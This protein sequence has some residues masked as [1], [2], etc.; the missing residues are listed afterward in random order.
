MLPNKT[1]LPTILQFVA[2]IHIAAVER[3]RG[4]KGKADP[5]DSPSTA[6]P[7]S[8][9]AD[10]P[11]FPSDT[12]PHYATGRADERARNQQGRVRSGSLDCWHVV[13]PLLIYQNLRRGSIERESIRMLDAVESSSTN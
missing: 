13:V 3:D 11:L 9:A 10:A 1:I 6:P 7:S 8:S 4:R 12:L 2:A 5:R